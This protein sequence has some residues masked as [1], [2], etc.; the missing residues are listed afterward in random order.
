MITI[1]CPY[2]GSIAKLEDS[3]RIYNGKSYGLMYICSK[4]PTCDA[5]VGVHKGT[6]KPLGRLANPELRTWK[7]KC[8]AL[9]DPLWKTGK[10]TRQD[11]YKLI[12]TTMGM[13]SEE[14]HV[15]KFDVED[16]KKLI[17]RLEKQL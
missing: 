10:M 12:Q 3:D 9:I 11:V 7:K 16:C 4:Y 15:G 13:T 14:A 6:D 5:Y 2:C 17:Q 8:H 1:V